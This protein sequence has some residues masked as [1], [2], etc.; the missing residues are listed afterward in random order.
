M[1]KFDLIVVT[2]ANAS[3]A[4]GYKAQLKNR[5][6]AIVVADPGDVRAGSLGATVN[7]LRKIP[8]RGKVLVCHSGGDAR[9][10]PGYAALG[11]AF[12]PLRDGRSMFEHIVESMEKLKMPRSGGV[13]VCSGDVLLTFDPSK[14]DFSAK[15]VTGVAYEDN[16]TQASLH[17]VYFEHCGT[18]VD[19]RQKPKV[20]RGRF[21]VDTGILFI[22]WPTARKMKDLPVEGDIYDEFPRMLLEGFAPFSVNT[23]PSCKF[24][25][26]GSSREL[27]AELG[28]G[29]VYTDAVGCKLSLAGG[30]IVTNVPA[31]R[32]ECI[33][34]KR[35]ECFTCLPVG[36]DGWYDLKYMLDDNFK[37]DGLWEK[38][39]LGEKMKIVDYRR[40]LKL[41]GGR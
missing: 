40:L 18:V 32:F 14:T 13:M 26:I 23:V 10:T 19:F 31:G 30:N 15:G 33:A 38:H 1:S 21:L 37:T 35:N 16:A 2:A 22:D 29:G 28:D 24:F 9:R 41:R 20:K 17:G 27:L 25:H 39:G 12:I 5:K 34:L 6:N 8:C 36:K 4:R 7:L 11:K 3:Q